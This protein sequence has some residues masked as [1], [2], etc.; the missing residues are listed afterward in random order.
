[1]V[2][3]NRRLAPSGECFV[4]TGTHIDLGQAM[5]VMI[6]PDRDPE[7]LAEW[8]RWYEHGHV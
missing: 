7:R 2:E 1:M 5:I 6:E 4:T 8:N 3:P